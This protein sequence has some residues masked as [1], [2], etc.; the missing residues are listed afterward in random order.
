M[1][2]AFAD[3]S[4]YLALVNALDQWHERAVNVAENLLG[5]TFVT[6]YVLV[7][8]GSALSRG[9]D[10]R[11]YLEL[12]RRLQRDGSTT[13]IPASASL[14]R[15]GVALFAKRSDSPPII[16]LSKRVSG[17]YYASKRSII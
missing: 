13:I 2:P 11:V 5:R 14:F 6:E 4:Y 15:E 9:S 3:T 17:R 10:R 8:L 16:T 1:N 12:L 7:E